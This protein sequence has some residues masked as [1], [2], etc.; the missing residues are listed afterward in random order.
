MKRRGILQ[1]LTAIGVGSIVVGGAAP[2]AINRFFEVAP[3]ILEIESNE[4]HTIQS[5]TT[6]TYSAVDWLGT[7]AQLYWGGSGATLEVR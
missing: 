1:W 4:T 5:G 7:G 3:T 2:V 6:E